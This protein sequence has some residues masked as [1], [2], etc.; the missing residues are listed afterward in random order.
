M[1]SIDKTPI[2]WRARWRTPDGASRSKTFSRQIDAQRHLTAVEQSKLTGGYVDPRAGRITSR[3]F[4]EQWRP[5]QIHRPSTATKVEG[6]LRRHVYPR[7][8]ARPIGDVRPS[9]LQSL[10]KALTQTLVP[11]TV[12][13]IYGCV[14]SIFKAAVADQIITIGCAAKSSWTAK[15]YEPSEANRS[16]AQ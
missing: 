9:E 3:S 8:G 12:E 5:V 1:G 11:H 14:S 7:I 10:V 15:S 16:L 6:I 4:A 2:G 13:V